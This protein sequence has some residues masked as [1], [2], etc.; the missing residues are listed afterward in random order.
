MELGPIFDGVSDVVIDTFG[1]DSVL[2]R[3]GV[4]PVTIKATI[5]APQSIAFE[6]GDFG[7][8]RTEIT[9]RA[10]WSDVELVVE[11]DTIEQGGVTYSFA[12]KPLSNGYGIGEF[13][14]ETL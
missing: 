5:R 2:T 3:A 13:T 4:D 9:G 8:Q 11:G 14:L 12:E 6:R 10:L 1:V 7:Q